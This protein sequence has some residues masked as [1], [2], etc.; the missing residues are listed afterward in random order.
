MYKLRMETHQIMSGHGN[1][2]YSGPNS[3]RMSFQYNCVQD[4]AYIQFKDILNR[5]ILFIQIMPK[6]YQVWDILNN[7]RYYK[8]DFPSNFPLLASISGEDLARL[9]W[10]IAPKTNSKTFINFTYEQSDV[11]SVIEKVV[12][13]PGNNQLIE[14]NFAQRQW[15]QNNLNLITEIPVS[16]PLVKPNP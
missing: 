14:I 16:V 9:L 6:N 11:G 4:S 15:G 2:V 10:G 5:R 7:Q 1:L 12:I 13:Q 3:G 8:T